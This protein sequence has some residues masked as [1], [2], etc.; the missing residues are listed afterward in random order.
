MTQPS[1]SNIIITLTMLTAIPLMSLNMF[2]PSL[3]MMAQ[4]FDVG[5]D[6]MAV[7]VSV[8]LIFTAVLQLLA[9]PVADKLGRRSV[10]LVGIGIFA[11]ASIGCALA[12]DFN[13]FLFYR[14]LQGAVITG[15]VL[16]R[17]IVSDVAAP[18]QAAVILGYIGMAMSLAPILAPSIGGFLS[19]AAGWRANFWFYAGTGLGLWLLVW[20][21]LPETSSVQ[22]T[23]TSKFIQSY[24]ELL[25]STR[26][27]AYTL[28]MAFSIGAFY[29]FISGL[30]LVAAEQL[31]MTQSQTGLAMGSMTVGFLCGSFLSSRLSSKQSLNT[32][33]LLGRTTA[34]FGLLCCF[35]LLWAGLVPPFVLFGGTFFAGL[36]NGL[37]IPSASSAILFVRKDLSAS[38]SGLFGAVIVVFGAIFTTITGVILQNQPTAI[39]LISLMLALSLVS[40]SIAFWL[41][42]PTR[43]ESSD[44]S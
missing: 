25:K 40:L 1:T 43:T 14:I 28:T 34:T 32:M 4:D 3:G 22:N 5:Y 36:G 16:S 15:A 37:T 33:I 10:L 19:D 11:A 42:R 39:A 20:A 8:Y 29:I 17:A 13:T 30:P 38:A 27:W 24:L 41:W 26:F 21:R 31:W 12:D 44:A 7:S 2:M 6:T 9:G 35:V 18:K 23:G